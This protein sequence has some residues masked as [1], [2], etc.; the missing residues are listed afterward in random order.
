[1]SSPFSGLPTQN[2]ATGPTWGFSYAAYPPRNRNQIRITRDHREGQVAQSLLNE[3]GPTLVETRDAVRV[4]AS[5]GNGTKE[6]PLPG[7]APALP[8]RRFET[9][10]SQAVI[11]ARAVGGKDAFSAWPVGQDQGRDQ[12]LRLSRGEYRISTAGVP[13]RTL[14][15]LSF[16]PARPAGSCRRSRP[17][18]RHRC[19]RQRVRVDLAKPLRESPASSSVPGS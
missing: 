13:R 9:F 19:G 18:E 2:R 12:Y 8:G 5:R 11:P 4:K 17:A 14:P 3:L 16:R 7:A 6:A 1:V 15:P 10:I